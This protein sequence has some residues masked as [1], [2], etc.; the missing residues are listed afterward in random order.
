[1][2]RQ[3]DFGTIEK[4]KLADLVVVAA[5]PTADVKNLRQVRWVV[6]GGVMRPVGELSAMVAS[7]A[8]TQE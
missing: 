4:G 5:D 6:R 2:G 7:E 8:G 1:M 3:A